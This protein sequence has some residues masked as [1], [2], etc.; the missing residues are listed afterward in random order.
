ML[1]SLDYLY[2]Y[3][4]IDHIILK[5]SCITKNGVPFKKNSIYVCRV[6]DI[7][8]NMQEIYVHMLQ[9]FVRRCLMFFISV[10][11]KRKE[12]FQSVDQTHFRVKEIELYPICTNSFIPIYASESSAIQRK[13]Y[14]FI[15]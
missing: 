3:F 2:R 8:N 10:I 6:S 1:H 7:P 15:Y 14:N 11:H 12:T 9:M 5:N 4:M 13:L